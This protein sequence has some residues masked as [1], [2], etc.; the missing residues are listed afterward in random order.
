M[1]YISKYFHQH[2]SLD[3]FTFHDE[4][5]G[6]IKSGC[7]ENEGDMIIMKSDGFPTYHLVV[8]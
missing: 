8:I 2:L 6:D 5:Y 7:F 3:S 1:E 4:I